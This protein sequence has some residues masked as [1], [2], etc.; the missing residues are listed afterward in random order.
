MVDETLDSYYP[1][2]DEG[3]YTEVVHENGEKAIKILKGEYKGIVFQ[4]GKIELFV[5]KVLNTF[6]RNF[7]C[8]LFYLRYHMKAIIMEKKNK[9]NN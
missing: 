1:L 7:V 8:S 9:L 2:F 4:Y 6:L 3:L 5:K